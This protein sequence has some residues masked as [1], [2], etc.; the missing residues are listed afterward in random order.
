MKNSFLTTGNPEACYGCKACEQAC[1]QS[2][3]SFKPNDEGFDYPV[4]NNELCID[5]GICTK[6]CAYDNNQKL[7][8]PMKA[9]A[10]QYKNK[11]QLLESAS[12]GAFPVFA[13]Y[14]LNLGGYVSGCIFN[15]QYV[16]QHIVTNDYEEIK[17]MSGSKYVQSDLSNIYTQIKFLLHDNKIV[18]FSG[19]SCQIAG[20][21]SFLKKSYENLY[22]IDLICHG[23]PSPMIF[24]SYLQNSYQ[25]S[26]LDYKFRDKKFNGWRAQGSVTYKNTKGKII[27]KRTTPFTDSYYNLYLQNSISRYCCY[28]CKFSTSYRIADITIGDYW[29]IREVF[30][31][32]NPND[33]V[34]AILINTSKGEAILNQVR[35]QLIIRESNVEDVV[36]GNGNLQRPSELPKNRFYIYE[37]LQNLGYRETVKQECKYQYIIPTIKRL[38]PSFL[39]TVIK[40][41]FK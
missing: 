25:N 36:K 26:I 17:K 21:L 28:K 27:K 23:V 5:C 13:N 19:T 22:T 40:K 15:N 3:I 2:A 11:P 29:N 34:S 38:T 39:K 18:L 35:D 41:L 8:H 30:P 20:L 37:K 31:D 6:V 9:Y 16:A 32:F 33:G 1:P 10:I 4:L 14:I 7:I 24:K 12:G